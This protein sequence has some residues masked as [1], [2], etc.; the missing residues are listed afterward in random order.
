MREIIDWLIGIEDR[1]HKV[2][3]RAAMQLK[4]DKKFADFLWHL[5]EDEKAHYEFMCKAAELIKDITPPPKLWN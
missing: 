4:N 3:E 5:A 2:Y 1:A